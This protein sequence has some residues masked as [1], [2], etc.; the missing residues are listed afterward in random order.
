MN[1]AFSLLIAYI[2]LLSFQ[3]N[4]VLFISLILFF[5]SVGVFKTGWHATTTGG[6][7]ADLGKGTPHK[8]VCCGHFHK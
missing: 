4:A 2:V 5:S 7:G 8:Y 1:S 6:L 3:T